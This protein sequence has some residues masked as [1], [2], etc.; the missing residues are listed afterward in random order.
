MPNWSGRLDT[1][2]T[3]RRTSRLTAA[4]LRRLLPQS[5]ETHA[6]CVHL[7]EPPTVVD[8]RRLDP[9]VAATASARP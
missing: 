4:T 3:P 7:D 9:E 8:L 5:V 2:R 1:R 6:L